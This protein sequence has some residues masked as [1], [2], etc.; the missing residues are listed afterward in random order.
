[1]VALFVYGSAVT[2]Y[3]IRDGGVTKTELNKDGSATFKDVLVAGTQG[4]TSR[5]KADGRIELKT[6]QRYLTRT[7][8]S[9]DEQ[10]VLENNGTIKATNLSDGTTTKTMTEVLAGGGSGGSV[11]AWATFDSDN[12]NIK[13][14]GN[15]SGVSNKGSFNY[16]FAFSNALSSTNYAVLSGGARDTDQY[17][18]IFGYTDGKQ[19]DASAVEL[20]G[21]PVTRK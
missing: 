18:R 12:G 2:V 16:Q 4:Y 5:I 10:I 20:T 1:M 15:I 9:D 11:Q 13:S 19:R 8:A 17:P 3:T 21:K 6:N 14:S 7:D